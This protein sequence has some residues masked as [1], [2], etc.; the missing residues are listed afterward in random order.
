MDPVLTAILDT[1]C[2]HH[3]PNLPTSTML[4]GKNDFVKKKNKNQVKQDC[5]QV[6]EETVF[7][8]L[9]HYAC[10]GGEEESKQAYAHTKAVAIT[11]QG[12][13]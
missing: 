8:G 13:F 5:F 4:A 10:F 6:L 3:D 9:L 11:S 7:T 12:C 1:D 2:R